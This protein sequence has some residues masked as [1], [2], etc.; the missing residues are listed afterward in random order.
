MRPHLTF[1]TVICQKSCQPFA[2]KLTAAS[3]SSTPIAS[4]TGINSRATNGNVMNA[5]ARI[6]PGVAKMIWMP[7]PP[8][9]APMIVCGP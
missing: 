9:H 4:I 8:N 6:K 3:S 1:G 5:V 2:P 7:C